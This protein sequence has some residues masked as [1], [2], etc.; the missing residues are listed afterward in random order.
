MQRFISSF[1]ALLALC[2]PALAQHAG[3]VNIDFNAATGAGAGQPTILFGGAAAQGGYWNPINPPLTSGGSAVI[4]NL[5]NSANAVTLSWTWAGSATR[6]VVSSN[7]AN[8]TG[9]NE[10]L[11][12]DG[13]DLGAPGVN[14]DFLIGTFA[15]GLYRVT[16]Y[17]AAPDSA[18]YRTSISVRTTQTTLASQQIGGAIAA[19]GVYTQGITHASHTIPLYI[20]GGISIT[21]STVVTFGTING[22]QV[23]RLSPTRLYVNS[24]QTQASDGLT[25]STAFSSLQTALTIARATP[26]VTEV[27]I[28]R[29]THRTDRFPQINN[30]PA[31][32]FDLPPGCSLY[33]G[34]VGG[35]AT[36]AARPDPMLPANQTILTGEIG[37]AASITDNALTVVT[38]SGAGVSTLDGLVIDRGGNAEDFSEPAPGVWAIGRTLTVS[39]CIFRRCNGSSRAALHAG[40]AST[41]T[42]SRC[43]FEDN[44]SSNTVAAVCEEGNLTIDRCTFRRNATR[45]NFYGSVCSARLG[46]LSLTNSLF[47]GNAPTL[48]LS[49]ALFLLSVYASDVTVANCTMADNLSAGITMNAP[50]FSDPQPSLRIR[51]CILWGNTRPISPEWTTEQQQIRNTAPAATFTV[52]DSII[53][54]WTGTLATPADLNFAGN[55]QFVDPDGP[56]NTPGNADDNYQLAPFSPAR[57][58]GWSNGLSS[59]LTVDLAGSPRR[60]DDTAIANRGFGASFIDRGCY[61]AQSASAPCPADLGST[62]GVAGPDGTRN[63]NDFIVFIDLFFAHDSRADVGRTGGIAGPDGAFNNN[64]FIVFIDDFFTPC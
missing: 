16:T 3:G 43:I 56:D 10:L 7:N 53:D 54:G 51:N 34:F 4:R 14:H 44:T 9:D 38:L 18:A 28:A 47:H 62:G 49:G 25:W 31:A 23:Q 6:G 29:G 50:F 59:T 8:T 36:L 55:P 40:P 42:A 17:A 64:D 46:T 45:A 1:A 63:N 52:T 60:V 37:D 33:G 35:E 13:L 22:L 11:M 2:S 21:A 57:D 27:W 58:S 39:R 48:P 15:P 61:E 12:D 41:V 32:T 26:T 20:N 5:G 19:G 30:D 24:E